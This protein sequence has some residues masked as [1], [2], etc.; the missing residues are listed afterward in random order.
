MV[1]TSIHTRAQGYTKN[2]MLHVVSLC[3]LSAD[4]QSSCVRVDRVEVGGST[5]G[6]AADLADLYLHSN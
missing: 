4:S 2:D 6:M 1:K 5:S 3:Q